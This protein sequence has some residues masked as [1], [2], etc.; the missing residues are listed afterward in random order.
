MASEKVNFI[1]EHVEKLVLGAC[2]LFLLY[3]FFS[4]VV[5]SSRTVAAP[6]GS[7]IGPA[8][9][10]AAILKEAKRI[11]KKIDDINPADKPVP[12]FI[13]AIKN[14]QN[15]K[16]QDFSQVA[17]AGMEI[18][19]PL[20]TPII[21]RE[22]GKAD[23]R[24]IVAAVRTPDKP[25]V[26]A[27]YK[28]PRVKPPIELASCDIILSYPIGQLKSAWKDV[29]RP[30]MM[31]EDVP[32][33]IYRVEAQV[34]EVLDDGTPLGEPR[35]MGLFSAATAPA[36]G[37][38]SAIPQVEQWDGSP[39][40]AEP[41][42]QAIKNWSEKWQPQMV[43]PEFWDVYVQDGGA[44]RWMSWKEFMQA[45]LLTMP[46]VPGGVKSAIDAKIF[47]SLDKQM[48]AGNVLIWRHDQPLERLKNYTY[49]VRMT[50]LNP[51]YATDDV[52]DNQED[53][54][55]LIIATD[56][57]A[58]SEP[59]SV[60]RGATFRIIGNNP[61]GDLVKVKIDTECLGQNVSLDMEVA[62]GQ[63]V[64]RTIRKE[65][66]DPTSAQGGNIAVDVS[67]D[68]GAIIVKTD[69]TKVSSR[70]DLTMVSGDAVEVLYLEDSGR[71][72]TKIFRPDSI[73]R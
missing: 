58:W 1:E 35:Q 63:A 6:G 47:D 28:V 31:P 26:F 32:V 54:K 68:T 3:A 20:P 9:V 8:D 65:M 50:F 24:Q 49:R 11:K 37:S 22:P 57:S 52:L 21:M 46:G 7:Q 70:T 34:R 48:A 40:K 64:S 27:S 5:S 10:D 72:R 33:V 66:K 53:A 59:V 61:V 44:K 36:G 60:Y 14:Q 18:Q 43:Q 29:F 45:R 12:R 69:R 73:K 56:W 4:W 2:G 42:R 41:V 13:D 19:S 25:V 71:L 39:D 15:R 16:I 17:A 55:K 67:F 62:A 38:G 23:Y 51:A 30:S